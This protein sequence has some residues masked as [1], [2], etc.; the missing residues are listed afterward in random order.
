MRF[1]L[2]KLQ[3]RDLQAQ[4]EICRRVAESLERDMDNDSTTDAERMILGAR[5]NEV[6]EERFTAGSML[7][8]LELEDKRE[9][10]LLNEDITQNR[11]A[12]SERLRSAVHEDRGKT[13]RPAMAAHR[14]DRSCGGRR[15][16]GDVPS[17]A[18]VNAARSESAAEARS[19]HLC[20]GL[21]Q[22]PPF[23]VKAEGGEKTWARASEPN[24]EM[25]AAKLVALSLVPAKKTMRLR[26]R[27]S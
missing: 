9:R 2:R 5:W 8:E 4:V 22:F 17:K 7:A 11:A 20:D 18:E 19:D 12:L 24:A 25:L 1:A 10:A 6:A 15:Y 23:P 16:R 21:L 27:I 3:I 26:V 14:R 13:V